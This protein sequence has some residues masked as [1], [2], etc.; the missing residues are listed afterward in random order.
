MISISS[1]Q[2][3]TDK[4]IRDFLEKVVVNAGV[5]RLSSQSNFEEKILPQIIKDVSFI[6]GQKP[7]ICQARKSIAG[8][9]I[10]E[11]QVVGV[12]VTLRRRKMI[13]F[14]ERLIRI[15]LPRVRDFGGLNLKAIDS[16]GVLNIGFKEQFVF[17]EVSPEQSLLTLS[18]GVNIIPKVKDRSKAI[19]AYRE[20]GVP[21]KKK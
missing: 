11:G 18:L 2:I 3:N 9:K 12:Q 4:K 15:V 13:D 14:F 19:D 8:F 6:T 20:L 16:H 5:G 7:K 10:R 21:L 17:P 1:K